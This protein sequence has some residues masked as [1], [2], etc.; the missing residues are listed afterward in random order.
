MTKLY[1]GTSLHRY[2]QIVQ[3]GFIC[4]APIGEPHLSMSTEK[5]VAEYFANLATNW[6]DDPVTES[7]ILELD[8]SE[9]EKDGFEL[10]PFS[11]PVWGDGECDWECEIISLVEIPTSYTVRVESVG[12]KESAE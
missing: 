6:S 3:D 5:N 11:S 2:K 12:F 10:H 1:H 4:P 8:M 7:V 9:L